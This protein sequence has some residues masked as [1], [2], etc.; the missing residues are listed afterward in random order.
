MNK[1]PKIQIKNRQLS[2]TERDY[3][4]IIA[5]ILSIGLITTLTLGDQQDAAILAT[6]TGSIISY[7]FSEKKRG[8]RGGDDERN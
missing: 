4:G 7:Y 3:R 2:I 6:L 1:T 8:N 5:I